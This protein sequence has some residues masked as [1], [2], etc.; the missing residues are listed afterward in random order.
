MSSIAKDVEVIA[1]SETS[2]DDAVNNCLAEVSKTVD[3][4]RQGPRLIEA[5]TA[6]GHR[7]GIEGGD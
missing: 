3:D 1:E 4:P 5:R 2:W 6:G 7:G